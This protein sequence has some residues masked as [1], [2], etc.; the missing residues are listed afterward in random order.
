MSR[1]LDNSTP[2]T[3]TQTKCH[4]PDSDESPDKLSHMLS[5]SVDM[6]GH[7]S[8]KCT[9]KNKPI[10]CD[11]DL[12]STWVHASCEKLKDEQYTILG[13]SP[14]IIYYCSVNSCASR[15]KT[16]LAE[17]IQT[18]STLAK[19]LNESQAKFLLEFENLHKNL[20]NLSSKLDNL[21]SSETE[22][23]NRIKDT[24]TTLSTV[25][26][27]PITPASSNTTDVVDEYLDRERRNQI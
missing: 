8:R 18:S 15:I 9:I 20:T 22:L 14:N 6:C 10:Q 5:K 23:Q 19:S 17:W 26:L 27:P 4:K 12:C 7:C 13:S 3:K 21:H 24:T 16:I 11:C 2:S 1:N 25:M